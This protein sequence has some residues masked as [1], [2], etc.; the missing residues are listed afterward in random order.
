MQISL[1]RIWGV[2]A[3]PRKSG[4]LMLLRSRILSL[5]IILIIG[6]ILL[7]SLLLNVALV[8]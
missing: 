3:Q 5:A 1:N 6:F 8:P 4:M 2:A 7:V